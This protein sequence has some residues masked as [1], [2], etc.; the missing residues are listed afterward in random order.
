[1]ELYDFAPVAYFTF[2]LQGLMLDV[3]FAAERIFGTNRRL[4]VGKPFVDLVASPESIERFEVLFQTILQ[5]SGENGC[6][7]EVKG[8]DGSVKV[9]RLQVTKTGDREGD[10]NC[11]LASFVDNTIRNELQLKLKNEHDLLELLV[12]RRTKELVTANQKL[13]VS[14][15]EI[16]ESEASLQKAYREIKRLKERLQ[17]ENIYLQQEVARTYNFDQIVGQSDTLSDVFFQIE[18]VAHQDTTVLLLGETGSG[19]GVIARALHLRSTRQERP[20]ITVNCSAL[21]GNLFE[22]ELFGRERGAFTGAT[23]RQMGRFELA[24]KGTIFLDEVGEMPLELQAKLLRVIQDGEFE[25][26]G[27]PRTIKTDVRIIAA[28]NRNLEAEV[29]AG[30]FR[31]DLFYRLN[32]FPIIIPPLRQRTEDILPLVHHFVAKFNKK[33][34]KNIENVTAETLRAFQEYRWP[35]NVREL[36]S[37]IERAAI[38]SQGNTL[39]V[40]DRFASLRKTE[41]GIDASEIQP[42]AVAERH[43]IM[44]ALRQTGWR[45]E[46]SKGAAA[47]LGLNP[48]TLRA[49]MRKHG[50]SARLRQDAAAAPQA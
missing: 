28:S 6:D 47:L 35:G 29:G 42:L 25:R 13:T 37:V 39:E 32:V 24:D 41:P 33:L 4:L 11:I 8:G 38:T 23:G 30:R 48:S 43:H 21:P 18:Q 20:M 10:N 44:Q 49:R 46:G 17:A 1:M 45:I 16:R 36:E 27:S 50:I 15:E 3:N 7:I 34:G 2:D 19:K 22:S 40:L 14:I 12:G 9:G 5:G 26:L 31:E